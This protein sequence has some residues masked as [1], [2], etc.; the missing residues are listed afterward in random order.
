[1][2]GQQDR[3]QEAEGLQTEQELV[4]TEPD[5]VISAMLYTTLLVPVILV[6]AWFF[7]RFS[8]GRWADDHSPDE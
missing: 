6:I 3:A 2:N 8:A 4:R 1:M 7:Y 5:P